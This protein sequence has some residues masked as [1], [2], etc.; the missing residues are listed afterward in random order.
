[1]AEPA[2]KITRSAVKNI[3]RFPPIKA[4]NGEEILL[5]S[6]QEAKYCLLLEFDPNVVK[7]LPHPQTFDISGGTEKSSSGAAY[8]AYTPDFLVVYLDAPKC[9]IEVKPR[10][11]A[12]HPDYRERFRRFEEKHLDLRHEF[13]VVDEVEIYS[14]PRLANMEFL[15]RYRKNPDLDMRNLYKCAGA[16]PGVHTLKQLLGKLSDTASLHEIYTWIAFGYLR[17]NLSEYKLNYK[18]ELEFHVEI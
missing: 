7:Y 16:T 14:Q 10:K 17:F 15:Y 1:M 6:I 8:K 4:N 5:E 12:D 9:Y 11:Y 3:V 18:T 13:L 2:R